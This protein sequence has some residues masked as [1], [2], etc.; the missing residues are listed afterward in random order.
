MLGNI[1]SHESYLKFIVEEFDKHSIRKPFLKD[2]YLEPI[3]WCSLINLTDT[4]VLTEH[5]YSSN[6]R[7]R[8][9]RNPYDM[10]RSLMLMHYLRETSVDQWVITLKATPIFAIL[11]GFSPD[12]VPGVGTF[13]D[14][15][16]RLWLH[17]TPHH[18]NRKKRKF[19]KPRKKESKT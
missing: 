1:R 17:S 9:P 8:K 5:R 14:F 16:K 12:N 4:A 13:Y 6:L 19:K 2:F 18:S 3:I 7:G 15:F 11:G 10:L